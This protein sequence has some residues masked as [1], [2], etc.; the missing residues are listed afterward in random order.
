LKTKDPIEIKGVTEVT[1]YTGRKLD[2][3]DAKAIF[4]CFGVCFV[5]GVLTG[6]LIPL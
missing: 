1:V 2:N 3:T 6:I 5:I 4:I